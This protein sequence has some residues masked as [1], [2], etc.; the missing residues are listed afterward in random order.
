MKILFPLIVNHYLSIRERYT[1]PIDRV[2]SPPPSTFDDHPSFASFPNDFQEDM[3][4]RLQTD[5]EQFLDVALTT[6]R[7]EK[8]QNETFLQLRSSISDYMSEHQSITQT[9]IDDLVE[10]LPNQ[11]SLPLIFSQLLHLCAS[12]QSYHLHSTDTNDLIL[13]KIL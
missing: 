1:I 13:Q 4:T 6:C 11:Y 9:N 12:T 5:M 7:E 3:D 10:I 8:E 2:Q